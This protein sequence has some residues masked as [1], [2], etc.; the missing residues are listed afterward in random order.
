MNF[1]DSRVNKLLLIL[2]IFL[3]SNYVKA[4]NSSLQI[5]DS[6]PPLK[7]FQ[8]I[9]GSPVSEFKKGQVYVVEFG[10][11]WCKPCAVAIPKLTALQKK[12]KKKVKV[13]GLFVMEYNN[14]P[15]DTKKPKY[16]AR[17]QKYV[18]KKGDQMDYSVAVDDPERTM[19]NTWLRAEGKNGVPYTFIVD[20][21]GRIAWIGRVE[22]NG[23]EKILNT[24]LSNEY[25][26]NKFIAWSKEDKKNQTPYNDK[27][28]LLIED[29]GGKSTNFLYRSILTNYNGDIQ[30]APPS[31]ITGYYL[32]HPKPETEMYLGRVQTT[33]TSLPHLY[34]M[35]Y[36]DTLWN[37]P[38]YRLPK[39]L[40][41]P[42][43]LKNPYTKRSYGKYWLQPIVEV[44][45]K[46]PFDW[47]Y[48]SPMN[49]YN[50]SLKVPTEKGTAKFLQDAMQRDLKTY[51]GYDVRVEIR[52]MPC[53]KITANKN[54]VQNLKSKTPGQPY[55][56]LKWDNEKGYDVKNAEIQDFIWKL[57]S[58]SGLTDTPRPPSNKTA[59][60]LP[61][62]DATEFD[63]Q[64]D[65]SISL[66]ENDK[67]NT[68]LNKHD[69]SLAKAFLNRLG[70]NLERSTH[71]MKVVVIRDPITNQKTVP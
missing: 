20:K 28:L 34:N 10:A 18:T 29:N 31:F 19:E 24:I 50:Y 58:N 36:G 22:S 17:V 16:V 12:Y 2:C 5:G 47:F 1:Q 71:P 59:N 70:L 66:E 43:T 4:Q 23:I 38:S 62:I 61:F 63:F 7:V 30:K 26:I 67:I 65:Y 41:F 6:A 60:I 13:I 52:E 21:Q 53:W 54:A 40:M 3:L 44:S 55:R 46:K 68:A 37:M 39:N 35:A 11:T 57:A 45:N 33:G 56:R 49:K 64:I 8:W 25:D 69:F 9:K 15:K 42:D 51:F 27:K 14:E 48:N 32:A